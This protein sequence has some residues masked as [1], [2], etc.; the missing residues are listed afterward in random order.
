[1]A[2]QVRRGTNAERLGI[3]PL[4]GELVYTT[5]TKQ[6]YVGDGA[7][8]GGITSIAGTIDSLLADTTPQLGGTLDLNSN[9]ITGI[10]N[11]NI[12]GTIT[13]T[14]N[15]NLGDGAGSDIIS[16]GGSLSGHLLPSDDIT[17]NLGSLTYQFKEAW[18]SQL[19]V[20]NQITADR[21]NATLIADDSTVVFDASTGLL[22]ASQLTG[23][24]TIDING[25]IF[26]DDSSIIVDGID[27]SIST[28][29][30]KSSNLEIK[31]DVIADRIGL[32]IVTVDQTSTFRLLRKSDSNI[33]AAAIQYGRLVF[34]RSDIVGLVETCSISGY[35]DGFAI[36]HDTSGL[37]SSASENFFIKD[38]AFAFG[39][40]APATNAKVDVA[41]NLHVTGGY[42]QFGSLDTSQR[43][44]LTPA[45]GMV[46]YNTTNN[47]F[48]GYQNSAWINL[49][50]GLAAS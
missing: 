16:V 6:L 18:I 12:T 43:N 3:T 36:S 44:A 27:G 1:M 29:V 7:T 17:W 19:N 31:T 23:I 14:G 37:H 8:A 28:N 41:G 39:T 49:D 2:L 9:D 26:S 35:Q 21:I 22:A 25:S 34:G 30:I 47:K 46:I 4:A 48:E 5:D 13:A 42:T 24:A 11:I 40:F 32:D 33:S 10:G 15:I 50:D 38:G 45:N 20:E